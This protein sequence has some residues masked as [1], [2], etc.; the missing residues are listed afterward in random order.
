MTFGRDVLYD[1]P[2]NLPLIR[3]EEV[4]HL[5]LRVITAGCLDWVLVACKLEGLLE[6]FF[7]QNFTPVI[8]AMSTH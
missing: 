5:H 4:Q 7:I 6:L 8:N 3:S 1:H 2:G